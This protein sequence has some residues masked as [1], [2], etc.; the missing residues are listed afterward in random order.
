ME[1]ICNIIETWNLTAYDA[2]E[3]TGGASGTFPDV[4][5]TVKVIINDLNYRSEPSMSGKVK[6]QT[7]KGVF[8][9]VEVKDGWGRLKS[10]AGWIYLLNP[11][12]CTVN[13]SASSGS[14]A[15]AVPYMVRVKV[16]DLRIRKG[17]GTNY[18]ATGSYTGKGVFTIVE[19]ELRSKNARL[20]EL[21]T[22]LNIDGKGRQAHAEVCC[23]PKHTAFGAG[24]SETPGA[25]PQYRQETKT[26]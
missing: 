10:G 8:T 13:G 23:C 17:A 18:A 25:A 26:T 1:K 24:S 9:I 16:S 3:S 20:V 7:G 11:S 5:F 22:L 15:S 12:Y 2:A 19:E 4:P 6:G 21:D 14:T